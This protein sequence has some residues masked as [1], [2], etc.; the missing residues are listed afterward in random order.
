MSHSAPSNSR[1]VGLVALARNGIVMCA[2]EVVCAAGR[3]A[4]NVAA[5]I[6]RVAAVNVRPL[7]GATIGHRIGECARELNGAFWVAD[8]AAQHP[9]A[10]LGLAARAT[11]RAPS[12]RR[13]R[14]GRRPCW[15]SK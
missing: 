9:A 7:A 14:G 8:G 12:P 1:P 3:W 11:D 10:A 5:T 4:Q 2:R 13:R 6:A 15:W